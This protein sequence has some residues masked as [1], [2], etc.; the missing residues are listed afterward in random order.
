MDLVTS[1]RNDDFLFP[2]Q[3]IKVSISPDLA[4]VAGGNPARSDKC[5]LILVRRALKISQ[6]HRVVAAY[7]DFAILLER[8]R[9]APERFSHGIMVP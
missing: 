2:A 4:N 5:P 3:K 8:E 6:R 9:H 7:D 1:S